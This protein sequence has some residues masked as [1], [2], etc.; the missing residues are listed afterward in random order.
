MYAT[1]EYHSN[2]K[3]KSIYTIDKDGKKNG[4]FLSF[5]KNGRIFEKC[6][7]KDDQKNGLYESFH[8]F[9]GKPWKKCYYKNGLKDGPSESYNLFGLLSSQKVYYMGTD[10]PYSHEQKY[11][12]HW[13][14]EHLIPQKERQELNKELYLID[15]QEKPTAERQKAKRAKVAEFRQKYPQKNIGRQVQNPKILLNYLHK[16]KRR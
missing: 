11:L 10:L 16:N 13:E 8:A 15:K 14:K 5:H 6:T 4:P 1:I 12:K 9:T 3:T 2:G 7:Y